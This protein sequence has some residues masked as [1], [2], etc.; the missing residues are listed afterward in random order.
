MK[1]E[2]LQSFV[3]HL[4]EKGLR[5]ATCNG[6]K[7]IVNIFLNWVEAEQISYT[8]ISYTELLSYINHLKERGNQKRTINYTL[9]GLKHF[10]NYLQILQQISTNPVETIRIKN[11][12]KRIPHDLL[13]WEEL[14]QLYK[15]FESTGITGKRNKAMLG[16]LVYQGLTTGDL[17]AL[18]VKDLKL[19]EGKIYIP[20]ITRSNSRIMKLEAFQV[21]QLQKYVTQVRPVLLQLTG[22]ESEKLFVS[23]GKGQRLKN[24]TVNLIKPI[25]KANPKVKSFSQI[26]ASVITEWMKKHNIRQVQYMSGHRYISSTGYYRT[27]TLETLQ[28]MIDQ[29]HPLK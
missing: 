15:N 27:N 11:V 28:E 19:E 29:L 10:Y 25:I 4:H 7:S 16:L 6:I 2:L 22:K 26:R 3:K 21:M 23:T 17:H 9:T 1:N 5:I 14:E 20:T 8:E 24:T 13:A 12:V 18:E